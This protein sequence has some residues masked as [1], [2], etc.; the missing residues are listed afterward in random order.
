MQHPMKFLIAVNSTVLTREIFMNKLKMPLF[1][2]SA[3]LTFVVSVSNAAPS[4]YLFLGKG[5]AK[6]YISLLENPNIKGAQIIYS[7]KNLEPKENIYNFTRIN[8][9][10]KLLQS[11]HKSLFI[12]I[13]DR[14]FNPKVIPVP[15]YLLT[16]KYNGG[17]AEQTDFPGAGKP[18]SEG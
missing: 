15:N 3:L 6:S 11:M 1:Y 18:L 8:A 4:I 5:P 7:W 9:D 13:Q 12:Q 17:V 10:L 2:M 14:S 16:N